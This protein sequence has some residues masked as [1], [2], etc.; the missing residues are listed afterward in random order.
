M[1]RKFPLRLGKALLKHA[2]K[3]AVGDETLDVFADVG[4]DEAESRVDAWLQESENQQAL[5]AAMARADECFMQQVGDAALRQWMHSL[6]LRDLPSLQAALD[7]LPASPDES[8]LETALRQAMARDWPGLSDAQRDLAV[9]VYLLC[10]R[11]ALLPLQE[12][13]LRII[14]RSVLRTEEK[15]DHLNEQLERW[16]ELQQVMVLQEGE[17]SYLRRLRAQTDRVRLAEDALSTERER[18]TQKKRVELH[19]VYVDLAVERPSL[20]LDDVFDRLKVPDDERPRLRKDMQ[21]WLMQQGGQRERERAWDVD[22][23]R[24]YGLSL[25]KLMKKEDDWKRHPLNPWVPDEDALKHALRPL[26]AIEAVAK[27]RDLVLLGDPGSG[28]STFVDYLTYILAGAQL[29]EEPGWRNMLDHQFDEPLFPIRIVIRRWSSTL[30]TSPDPEKGKGI[31]QPDVE[32]VYQI[33]ESEFRGGVDRKQLIRRLNHPQTLVMFDGLDEAPVPERTKDYNHRKVILESI[34]E[35]RRIHPDCR[36]LVTSRIRP[37]NNPAYRLAEFPEAV[38]APLDDHRIQRFVEKWYDEMSRV[39]EILQPKKAA[40]KH[41]RLLRAIATRPT[42]REMAGTPLLLTMLAMVNTHSDLPERRVELYHL[43]VQQLLWEW[44]K[45]KSEEGNVPRLRELL[46]DPD[47]P[48]DKADFERM[49]WKLTYEAHAQ[50]GRERAAAIQ[51]KDLR[52]AL[53]ELYAQKGRSPFEGEAWSSRVIALMAERSGLLVPDD[54]DTFVFP[55][56]SFQEYLAARWLL[57][58]KNPA[59]EFLKLIDNDIWHEVVLLACGYL[60]IKD[61]QMEGYWL[62]I[63]SRLA[64]GMK[65]D[66]SRWQAPVL[67][68]LAWLEYGRDA[69]DE[70]DAEDL[71]K[72]LA[73]ALT[74]IM[75]NPNLPMPAGPN[76]DRVKAVAR[77]RLEAGLILADLG[78]LPDDLDDLIRINDPDLNYPFRIGKYPVTNVQFRR[79]WA[80]GGYQEGR[81]W[82]HEGKRYRDRWHWS[83]PRLWND[84]RFNKATQPVVGVSWFEAYAYCQWLTEVWREKGIIGEDEEVRLPSEAEWEAAAG[85]TRYAWGDAFEPARVNSA[86]SGLDQPA[87]VHMY[88]AGASPAGVH[89]LNGN[90]WEWTRD[91]H[92]LWG[93]VARGGSFYQG[94]EGVTSAARVNGAPLVGLDGGGYRVVVVP[95][96][97]S[98]GS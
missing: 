91:D 42:L 84:A 74:N 27:H 33:L 96:S 3:Q 6:P 86:E 94:A 95:I 89:A 26:T 62:G 55:H 32:L 67:A 53:Q 71:L 63:I 12:Q 10:M 68:G 7:H 82:S 28:K 79:F 38:L 24:D 77:Q 11:R 66:F 19:R 87:P 16:I 57:T 35:F 85:P 90:V 48:I 80:A 44:D 83:E 58:L 78:V 4:L 47:P 64:K 65:H 23:I 36:I 30:R 56:R 73:P 15:I 22:A 93:K 81:W 17:K 8:A 88:P 75:Q 29:E 9:R 34:R 21:S 49:L 37:Y 46:D 13:A 25:A 20:T 40:Q 2:V 69:L 18:L 59:R 72:D 76:T 97:H 54:D 5:S 98:S 92:E 39:G 70:E 61:V 1:D 52:Q 14:G 51:K 45:R 41:D 43:V 60:T 31:D 50:S